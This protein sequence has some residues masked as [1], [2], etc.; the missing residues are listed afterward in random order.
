MCYKRLILFSDILFLK[1]EYNFNKYISGT[2]KYQEY[3]LNIY[4][5]ISH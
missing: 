4:E 5:I 2:F 3:W 1:G